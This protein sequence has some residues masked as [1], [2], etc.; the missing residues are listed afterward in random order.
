MSSASPLEPDAE[1][2]DV[3]ISYPRDA[4][5]WA[6]RLHADLSQRG[7]RCFIDL[8]LT[9][10]ETWTDTMD[11]ALDGTS[12][13]LVLWTPEALDSKGMLT[14]MAGFEA[15]LRRDV[16]H[17][18]LLIPLFL[19]RGALATAPP[20]LAKWEGIV[21]DEDL[22]KIDT[23]A[24]Q[25]IVGQVELAVRREKH[26]V[27]EPTAPA[28]PIQTPPSPARKRSSE[29]QDA[30][31]APE[32]PADP[33]DLVPSAAGDLPASEDLLGY[34]PLVRALHALLDDPKTAL[35]LAI[36]VTAP[37]GA[38]KSSVMRQLQG[39]LEARPAA[40]IDDAEHR[41]THRN[42]RTVRF[43]AWK[44]ERSERLWA[45]LAKAIYD[46]SQERMSWREKL[47]FR[48]RLERRRLG[49]WK[50]SAV[51]I[52]PLLV[53]AIVVTAALSADLPQEGGVLAVLSAAALILGTA[54]R[55]GGMI[56][57][58][59]RRAI[60]KYAAR[61]DYEAQLG[62]TAEADRE[63]RKLV[64]LLAPGAR[65]GLAVFVDD[66]DR[67]SSAHVVEVVEAMNQIFNAAEDHRCVF[68]LG[69][70]QDVVATNIS[71]A[72]GATVAQLTLDGN[73]LGKR[74]GTEFL[75][76]LV[77]LSVAIPPP[78]PAGIRRLMT[79]IV[80][81]APAEEAVSEADVRRAQEQIRRVA[82]DEG[83]E[84]VATAA[85]EVAAGEVPAPAVEEAKHRE[86]ARRLKDSPAVVAAEFAALD[87]LAPN[88]RQ[89]KRFHNAFRLQLYVAS[90]DDRVTFDFS[91]AQLVALARW[92]ALRLRWP[93]L[94]DAI[95][96]EP[97][98]LAVLEAA[99]NGARAPNGSAEL[100][101]RHAAWLADPQ[102]MALIREATP[103]RRLSALRLD[104][105]VRIA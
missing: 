74:F 43:D 2:Y 80:N 100:R 52:A 57:N 47:V 41:E 53:A 79:T 72:Y 97:E 40:G 17:R 64:A 8:E 89:V 26:A 71:V 65:D 1:S 70:D 94:A 29:P 12:A 5:G 58:P 33:F 18:R 101:T 67:C 46:Q 51:T 78:D 44:Y 23:A 73:P 83:L 98:L 85:E 45:A 87:F 9:T 49:V 92:V 3:Y 69:L 104:A 11:A 50:F 88:P 62:F 21:I 6:Q 56:V 76:K 84:S 28:P 103:G 20:L 16:G 25:D 22:R 19:G 102:V 59:F 82:D 14:E 81:A 38:G 48:L 93:G 61:P 90:E 10:G 63:I 77:Q 54:S 95:A 75:A 34:G 32:P 91:P 15:L 55:Y 31:A 39:L 36:A 30:S 4:R 7:L 24:W 37:W 13:L 66:L 27:G 96:R 105:F 86:R 60:E 35:P 42:W 68:V 99:A